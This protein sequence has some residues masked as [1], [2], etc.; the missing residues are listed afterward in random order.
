VDGDKLLVIYPV[1]EEDIEVGVVDA[2]RLK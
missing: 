1:N 2:N